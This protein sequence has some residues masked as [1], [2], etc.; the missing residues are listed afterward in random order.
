[1]KGKEGLLFKSAYNGVK[2]DRDTKINMQMF[3]ASA[4]YL[5]RNLDSDPEG[6]RK[7]DAIHITQQMQ[8]R[9]VLAIRID[10]AH[11]NCVM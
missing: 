6:M 3:G 8:Q 9:R 7:L 11:L 5:N 4:Y 1:V 2:S 10:N